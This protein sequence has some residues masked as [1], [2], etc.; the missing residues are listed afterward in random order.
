MDE[1]FED[2]WRV[3]RR[4]YADR[5]I[6]S[7][8]NV[9]EAIDRILNSVWKFLEL[10]EVKDHAVIEIEHKFNEEQTA[11]VYRFRLHLPECK[12]TYAAITEAFKKLA[13][14]E[15][16]YHASLE[17][18]LEHLFNCVA[19]IL[20]QDRELFAEKLAE[21][22]R[23]LARRKKALRETD[24]NVAFMGQFDRYQQPLPLAE[25]AVPKAVVVEV[26]QKVEW[27]QAADDR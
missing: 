25:P 6:P 14:V 11:F 5:G 15:A 22:E 20:K 2:D 13:A 7:T 17:D 18:A 19:K 16:P 3:L 8:M 24:E 4:K 1:D 23:E 21:E 27:P 26:E 10:E 12:L 9:G